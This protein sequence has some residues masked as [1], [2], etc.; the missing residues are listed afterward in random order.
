MD[1]T[2]LFLAKRKLYNCVNLFHVFDSNSTST[3]LGE[4]PKIKKKSS[5]RTKEKMY[6]CGW[7]RTKS[8]VSRQKKDAI[9]WL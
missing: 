6:S 7:S 9:Q 4:F 2:E 5:E 3:F 8:S 1:F